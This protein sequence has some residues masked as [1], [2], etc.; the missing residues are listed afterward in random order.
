MPKKIAIIRKDIWS[1]TV[2]IS[3]NFVAFSEDMNFTNQWDTL[4]MFIFWS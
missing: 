4:Y 2:E 1:G 3:Q